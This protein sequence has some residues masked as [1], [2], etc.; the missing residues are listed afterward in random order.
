MDLFAVAV[1]ARFTCCKHMRLCL[2]FRTASDFDF[3]TFF[4]SCVSLYSN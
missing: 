1:L 4:D 3:Q 2:R